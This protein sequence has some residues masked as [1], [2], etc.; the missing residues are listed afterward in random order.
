M[1]DWPVEYSPID[2]PDTSMAVFAKDL[3]NDFKPFLREARSVRQA[4]IE[5]GKN[6]LVEMERLRWEVRN[7]LDKAK[8]EPLLPDIYRFME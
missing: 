3:I 8:A 5:D 1:K 4:D 7:R 2:P 6:Q